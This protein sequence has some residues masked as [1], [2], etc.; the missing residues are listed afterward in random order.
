MFQ[1]SSM[2]QE[3]QHPELLQPAPVLGSIV[4]CYFAEG[5]LSGTSSLTAVLDTAMVRGFAGFVLVANPLYGD[6]I[7]Q[8]L[9]VSVPGIL[10]PRVNDT[11]VSTP[12]SKNL[13]IVSI[14][15]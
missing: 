9:P 3:C 11:I 14:G 5:F 7:A 1:N 15:L 8:P 12:D 10:I 13:S 4:I 2:S 6:F